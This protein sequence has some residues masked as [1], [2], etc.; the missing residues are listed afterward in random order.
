MA[1]GLTQG[2]VDG[3]ITTLKQFA[4]RCARITGALMTMRDVS[5]DTP[6]PEQI[7]PDNYHAQRLAECMV[8]RDHLLA[9]TNEEKLAYS[10]AERTKQI[11]TA[12]NEITKH[13]VIGDRIKK[14]IELV[15]AWEPP[16]DPE[17]DMAA[18]KGLMKEQLDTTLRY[19]AD[20]EFYETVLAELESQSQLAPYE[21]ALEH[22]TASIEYHTKYYAQD[23]ANAKMCTAWIKGLN[24][25]L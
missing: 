1:S 6:F 18:F 17:L 12:R 10:E 11:E 7:E 16:T 23:V 8:E 13:L 5:F 22:A 14:M 20:T 2:V 9:M 15:D 24:S 21:A 19:D 3:D 4:Q 25:S